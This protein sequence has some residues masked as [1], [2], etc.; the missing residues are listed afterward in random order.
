MKKVFIPFS[1]IASLFLMF[2]V[3][4]SYTD[5]DE[6]QKKSQT[7]TSEKAPDNQIVQP[8]PTPEQIDFAGERFPVERFDVKERLDRE[9][10][11]NTYW[12]SN[13]IMN[14]KLAHKYFPVI[15]P[16][17]AEHG[18]P[19][20]FKYLAV[21]ESGLRN[22]TSPA[23]AKGIWQFMK[24]TARQYGMVVNGEIDERLNLEKATHA[25]CKYLKKSKEEHGSWM[26]AAAA[27]NMG[28]AKLA[29]TKTDQRA[30]SY[31][32]LNMNQETMRYVFRLAA[33][34]EIMS[35]PTK[36]GFY[37][38]DYIKYQ[39]I[40]DTYNV[41]V[42]GT[43]ENW[44]DWAAKYNLGYRTLKV[45]NPWIVDHKLVNKEKRKYLVRIPK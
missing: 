5:N 25:A 12:H 40:T 43:V 34:K 7:N 20:D 27:Y 33:M 42:T 19:D 30:K 38:D 36:Y 22:V 17:L 16:I 3:F 45:Y 6:N 4:S 24:G 1:I 2:V 44:G 10:L 31:F 21:A 14:I 39:P 8:L 23:G 11:V 28:G 18:V 35:Q 13:T 32:D 29:T 9:I 15:E 37:I 41:E 26:F